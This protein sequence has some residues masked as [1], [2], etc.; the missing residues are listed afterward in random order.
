MH[1]E[2]WSDFWNMGGY[3]FYVWLAF[4]VTI[5]A[6]LLL[7]IESKLE[8]KSLKSQVLSEAARKERIRR[9]TKNN[10]DAES[11]YKTLKEG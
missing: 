9:T 7:V 5:G 3:A 2:S 1:F 8:R 11:Q 10:S 4:S 6:M